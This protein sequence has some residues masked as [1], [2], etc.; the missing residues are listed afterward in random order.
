MHV[1]L[2]C[3]TALIVFALVTG[4]TTT[5]KTAQAADSSSNPTQVIEKLRGLGAAVKWDDHDNAVAVDFSKAKSDGSTF[6]V[7][8]S[9]LLPRIA[10]GT[11][12]PQR[13]TSQLI[14]T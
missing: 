14:V 6:V 11:P 1:K 10:G 12:V 8:A 7:Q 13:K 3:E 2:S 4:I 9:R 5:H